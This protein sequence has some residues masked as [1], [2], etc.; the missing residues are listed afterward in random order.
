MPDAECAPE[1]GDEVVRVDGMRRLLTGRLFVIVIDVESIT[2][3]CVRHIHSAVTVG[4]F[5]IPCVQGKKYTDS[6]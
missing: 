1:T 2:T 6:P 4:A 3:T 5:G